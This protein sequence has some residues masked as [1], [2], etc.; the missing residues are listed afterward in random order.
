MIVI[1]NRFNNYKGK[2]H[3]QFYKSLKK[4]SKHTKFEKLNDRCFSFNQ[5]NTSFVMMYF[6]LLLTQTLFKFLYRLS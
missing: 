4:H 1:Y 3:I 6:K 2:H 5:Q